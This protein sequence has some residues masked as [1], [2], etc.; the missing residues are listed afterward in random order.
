[1]CGKDFS[2]V[3]LFKTMSF[4]IPTSLLNLLILTCFFVNII[5][6]IMLL[7]NKELSNTRAI[8]LILLVWLIPLSS[9]L[10]IAYNLKKKY[11]NF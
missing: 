4:L 11:L 5:T 3:K 9:L 2:I 6:T 1:M 10:L 7:N 8:L